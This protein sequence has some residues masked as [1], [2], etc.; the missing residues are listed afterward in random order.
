M[1]TVLLWNSDK[2]TRIYMYEHTYWSVIS[3]GLKTS[4]GK[5]SLIL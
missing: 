1:Q 3:L 4:N 5:K 2:Q